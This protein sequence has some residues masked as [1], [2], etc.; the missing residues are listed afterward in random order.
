M[1][2]ISEAQQTDLSAV[3]QMAGTLYR[4]KDTEML[5]QEFQDILS[6]ERDQT[7]VAKEKKQCIGFIHMALRFEYVEGAENSPVAYMEGIYVLLEFRLQHAAHQLVEAGKLW[8]L[9]KGCTQIASD[10]EL[11]NTVSH[12]FHQNTGFKEVNRL[13]CYIKNIDDE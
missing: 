10:A 2:E 8:A 4:E 7:F 3:V 6:S 5:E 11:D 1:I 9:E 13:V 12:R